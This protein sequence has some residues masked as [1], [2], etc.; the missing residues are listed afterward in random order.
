MGVGQKCCEIWTRL[1]MNLS[2]SE[3][4]F[5]SFFVP[6]WLSYLLYADINEK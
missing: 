3:N 4:L 5:E 2:Y 1:L 6:I